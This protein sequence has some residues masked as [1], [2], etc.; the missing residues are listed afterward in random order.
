M[1]LTEKQILQLKR[2]LDRIYKLKNEILELINKSANTGVLKK[3]IAE[4]LL[5]I[6][7]IAS[8]A[9]PKNEELE[10]F[11]REAKMRFVEM[12]V[13]NSPWPVI[14]H[15]TELFC[16]YINSIVFDFTRKRVRILTRKLEQGSHR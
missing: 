14:A 15:E 10:S 5:L 16:K 11:V 6:N 13:E 3:K 1:E 7:T 9:S 12:D 8:R 4:V 2:D